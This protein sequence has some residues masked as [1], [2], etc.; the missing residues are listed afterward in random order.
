MG[1]T[2]ELRNVNRSD[3]IAHL[4]QA[5]WE[6]EGRPKGRDLEFWLQAES[7]LK[8]TGIGQADGAEPALDSPPS[9][10]RA[11]SNGNSVSVLHRPKKARAKL[12]QS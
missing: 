6:K 8:S 10:E 4:A 2:P 3:A 9:P 1:F 12:P 11:A 7:H 5:L